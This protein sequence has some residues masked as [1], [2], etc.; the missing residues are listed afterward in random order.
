[1]GLIVGY[2]KESDFPFEVKEIESLIDEEPFIREEE[3]SLAQ[4][5]SR[6]YFSSLGEALSLFIPFSKGAL[7]TKPRDKKK[8]PPAEKPLDLNQKQQAILKQITTTKDLLHLIYGVTGSGKTHLYLGLIEYFLKK[9]QQV[10]LL[11]PEIALTPQTGYFF[12]A[13]LPREKV[14]IVH[15]KVSR[16]KKL[17]LY[18]R[19]A[20]GHLQ[21]LIG[22]RSLIFAPAK[23]LG[24]IIIDEEHESTYKN[25]S[26]PRYHARQVAQIR[27]LRSGVKLV[28]GS[29]TPSLDLYYLAQR[30]KIKL[31]TLD[32]RFGDIPLPN[33]SLVFPSRTE[34][35]GEATLIDEAV[36]HHL[37]TLKEK[38][39]QGIIYLN[40]RGYSS[41]VRC[42]DCNLL[43]K[44][45]RC[46]VTY[47]YHKQARQLLC[48]YC[49]SRQAFF[50]TCHRCR[51][52]NV[53]HIGLGTE[54]IME[55]LALTMPEVTFARVDSDALNT[56]SKIKK[57]FLDFKMRKIDILVGTQIVSKGHDF[58]HVSSVVILSPELT[59]T[60]PDFRAA[61]KAFDQITQVS[62]RAGR[63]GIRGE[64]YI[65]TMEDP[66]FSI[67]CGQEQNYLGFY[68]R[69][70]AQRREF[71][72][73]PF[74]KLFRMVIR[75]KI[76]RVAIRKAQAIGVLIRGVGE[77]G[78]IVLG[79][80]PCVMSKLN[81]YY[82]WNI[83]FKIKDYKLFKSKM[84]L[85]KGQIKSD[86]AH[87]VEYD[88]DPYD[89][90]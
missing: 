3:Y 54:K 48:H 65:Q 88:M 66:H 13:Y 8:P 75:S 62:G 64:V 15:S 90:Y 43:Y 11:L 7:A 42:F 39:Q 52:K 78:S 31:H 68:Q 46:E 14:E 25:N 83:I 2:L 34:V 45:P 73:P 27:A 30:G 61:E 86:D 12:E 72:Y 24:I 77:M 51:S 1:M 40:K 87:Y 9:A 4:W 33:S 50:D 5:V 35:Q 47:T 32:K 67:V 84:D 53:G 80:A 16:G 18:R 59:L 38:K 36:Y 89:M 10:I 85:I 20:Q 44:C 71:L 76:E 19:F 58:P 63:R 82:R 74:V 41:Y 6:Y 55:E 70:I 28:L 29:A 56:P 26:V 57:T 60:L 23:D 17:Q 21:I 22:T 69:E 81:Q 79:P 49:N 37:K